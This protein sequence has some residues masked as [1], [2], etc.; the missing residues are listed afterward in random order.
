MPEF[1]PT[2]EF[3]DEVR[4]AVIVPGPTAATVRQLRADLMVQA[5]QT[6][7][8]SRR[9]TRRLGWVVGVVVVVLLIVLAASSPEIVTAM[10]H[11]LRYIPGVGV[12]ETAALRVLPEPAMTTREGIT[13]TVKQASADAERT[14]LLLNVEGFPAEV[15]GETG[16]ACA[17]SP[18]LRLADGTA[19]PVTA[20]EG[21][22]WD[23]GYA[24]RLIFPVLPPRE[25]DVILEM[26]CLLQ[27]VPGEW[28][29]DWQVPLHF[30]ATTGDELAP[31]IE[32]PATATPEPEA[33]LLSTPDEQDA[34]A[35]V[36]PTVEAEA[37]LEIY[38]IELVLEQVVEL[39]D[40]YIFMCA[41]RWTDE[42][43][44][45]YGIIPGTVSIHAADGQAV[46]MVEV[47]PDRFAEPG[48]KETVWAYQ[49]MGKAFAPPFTLRVET[50][51]IDLIAKVP[52][53]FDPGEN[54]QLEQT[55]ELD[56]E[57]IVEPY[58]IQVRFAELVSTSDA[59]GYRFTMQSAP[60][61][62]G[63]RLLD[64]EH[65]AAGGGGGGVPTPGPFI[66]QVM[67]TELPQG[68]VNITISGISILESG[69]WEVSWTPEN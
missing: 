69:P 20:G 34:A 13:L 36:S 18:L 15:T 65:A 48:S 23:T 27:V 14:I 46:S 51:Q 2:P 59:V 10:K 22:G 60:E 54:P 7:S 50:I 28:P 32:L 63:V 49:T 12:V 5:A 31:V 3:E 39:D 64:M 8:R 53:R 26:P 40:G 52:F 43:I 17:G 25:N 62:V 19:L 4:A 56:Q 29:R 55:W 41:L 1:I 45:D 57:V 11:L 61:V 6:K 44:I 68:A 16:A 9:R 37:P 42:R 67:Y 24:Q 35:D 47:A 30:A 66:A 38:P 21:H 58:P 33:S